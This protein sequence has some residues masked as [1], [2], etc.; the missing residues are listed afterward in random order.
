MTIF[1]LIALLLAAAVAGCG[2]G[3]KPAA[4]P[5]ER[6]SILLVTLDTTRYDALGPEAEGIDTP[7]FNAVAARGVRFR[8]AYATAP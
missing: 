7:G 8:Q 2:R 5:A 3:E 6:P 4:P 1:R